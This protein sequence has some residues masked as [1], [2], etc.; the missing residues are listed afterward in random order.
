MPKVA[1]KVLD[2]TVHEGRLLAKVQFDRILPPKG[3]HFTAKWGSIRSGSQNNLYWSFLSWLI[4]HGG[5]KEHGHFCA[6]ALH[7]DLKAHLLSQTEES[8]TTDL[9]KSEFSEYIQKVDAFMREFFGI[10]TSGFWGDVKL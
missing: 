9:T 1:G 4:D 10:D 5:L 3:Q 6:E 7:L 2:T 8:T